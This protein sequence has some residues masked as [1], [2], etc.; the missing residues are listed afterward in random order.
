MS[1]GVIILFAFLGLAIVGAFLGYLVSRK[2]DE[3]GGIVGFVV[4]AA[5]MIVGLIFFAFLKPWGYVHNYE[6]GYKFDSRDGSI[7]MLPHTGYNPRTPIFESIYTID[8]RPRQVC[9]TVGGATNT[10][11]ANN[12][13]ANSRVLNCK[14][15]KFNPAGLA[16]FIQFHGADDYSDDTLNDLLKL[17]AYD[18]SGTKYPFL[19]VLRELKD[20]NGVVP[21]GQPVTEP[22]PAPSP[23]SNTAATK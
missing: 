20:S 6:L 13:G 14:L 22:M 23:I 8:L 1:V 18:G 19:T 16:T 3:H 17:Y 10:S 7:S 2:M 12:G 15:V 21:I 9:I 11:T 4:F 5:V